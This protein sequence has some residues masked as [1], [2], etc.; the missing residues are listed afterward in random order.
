MKKQLTDW[1]IV[2]QDLDEKGNSIVLMYTDVDAVDR[3]YLQVVLQ[4]GKQKHSIQLTLIDLA[5]IFRV[6]NKLPFLELLEKVNFVDN[7]NTYDK[8]LACYT[9]IDQSL[10]FNQRK[11]NE[12]RFGFKASEVR[13]QLSE[14]MAA[15][16]L[17]RAVRRF[18]KKK[19]SREERRI[20]GFLTLSG[21]VRTGN[22][23]LVYVM[24]ANRAQNQFRI[25]LKEKNQNITLL[26]KHLVSAETIK[27][28]KGFKYMLHGVEEK[29]I[30]LIEGQNE[31]E[32]IASSVRAL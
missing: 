11:F 3:A 20:Q 4:S 31:L 25:T 19:H 5:R 10:M 15:R 23:Y 8:I 29:L 13:S 32:K 6:S 17:Q 2:K 9:L 12:L 28:I 1:T 26:Q 16:R 7:H 22:Y 18:L 14:D 30:K 24:L 21:V 27:K